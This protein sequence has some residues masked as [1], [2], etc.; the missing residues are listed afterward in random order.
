MTADP[1]PQAPGPVLEHTVSLKQFSALEN[2]VGDLVARLD[3][4]LPSA[5]KKGD[6]GANGLK[7]PL[8]RLPSFKLPLTPDSMPGTPDISLPEPQTI[9][10]DHG[11]IAAVTESPSTKLALQILEIIQKY[12]NNAASGDNAWPGK[13]KFLPLVQACVV[14]CKP[15]QMVL[16]AFP[17]KSP[18]RRDKTIGSMP[19]LGEE[20][21][22]MH[23]NGL[24]ESISERYEHGAQV[25]ITSDG[26]V[27][28]GKFSFPPAQP[29]ANT[30]R[31]DGNR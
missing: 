27:Y 26:L 3:Q 1:T 14:N 15:V 17:F 28:N 25:V 7:A 5:P 29:K 18:N 6:V 4:L 24:C 2:R 13:I 19:D 31:L 20:L 30:I 10:L 8:S 23:L 12:R 22:L 9:V 16:P 21:A 11:S